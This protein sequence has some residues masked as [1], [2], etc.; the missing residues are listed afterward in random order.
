M[1]YIFYQFEA[2]LIIQPTKVKLLFVQNEKAFI[3]MQHTAS[4][5]T[6]NNYFIISYTPI[7][8]LF[9]FLEQ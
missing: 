2:L 3:F 7:K 4:Q 6:N 1:K 8:F 9:A 5:Y